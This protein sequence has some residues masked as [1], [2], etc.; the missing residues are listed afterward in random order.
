M[1]IIC[2]A[3]GSGWN[4]HP[5]SIR[6][7]LATIAVSYGIPVIMTKDYRE[8]AAL[9]MVIAKREQEELGKDFS[10]HASRKPSTLGEQQEYIVSALPGVGLNLAKPLL[11]NFKSVKNVVN[12]DAKD[13]EGIEK[14]GPKKAKQIRDVL[15]RDY[16][17]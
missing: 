4:V 8:T 11:R 6:G 2:L 12:A 9:L 15:D 16:D 1:R 14:I 17:G 5:N 3:Q 13:L 7:M 10:P